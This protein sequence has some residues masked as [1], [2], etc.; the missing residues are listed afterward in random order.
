MASGDLR[1]IRDTDGA[2]LPFFSPDGRWVAFFRD[3]ELRKV[4]LEGGASVLLA[5]VVDPNGA[6]WLSDGRLLVGR[7]LIPE[8]GGAIDSLTLPAAPVFSAASPLP[9]GEWLVGNTGNQRLAVR[10][11]RTGK[12]LGITRLGPR[13]IESV[14]QGELLLGRR[15]IYLPSGHLLY[16]SNSTNELMTLPFDARSRNVLGNPV[17]VQ[18]G[19]RK[20][21][22]R[23][24]GHF[25]VSPDGTL[26]YAPGDDAD[27]GTLSLV[28]SSG[29]TQPLPF[30]PARYNTLR[31]SPDG[32]RLLT[33]ISLESGQQ[34]SHLLD[35][36]SGRMEP[37][38]TPAGEQS[39]GWAWTSRGT[40]VVLARGGRTVVHSL[41]LGT[42]RPLT[43]R[44]PFWIA[45]HPAESVAVAC[46]PPPIGC[47]GL[48]KIISLGSGAETDGPEP[49]AQ[50]SFSPDGKWLAFDRGGLRVIRFPFQGRSF[51]IP[52]EASVDIE[53]PFWARDGAAIYYRRAREIWRVSFSP[54][55]GPDGG[56][57]FG[58][59]KLLVEGPFLR[60]NNWGQDLHPDGRLLLSIGSSERSTPYLE[61]VTG[62][63]ALLRRI[64]PVPN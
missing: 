36:Q 33:S 27:M 32:T 5:Q 54:N 34:V 4:D 35:L 41:R 49:G 1:E 23:A 29:A 9:G 25:A 39:T 64:A 57:R 15:P 55:G 7:W 50:F 63:P 20:E 37:L 10:S 24:W 30:P 58:T 59:P 44:V 53:Q 56:P 38:L 21:E 18:S 42:E 31:L 17:A 51:A 19:V 6:T 52:H 48:M 61:V 45:V 47:S 16:M 28:D 26:I 2:R 62:L 14:P 3:N 11:L 46:G 40:E 22:L 60:P 8:G 12:V 13:P 43:D